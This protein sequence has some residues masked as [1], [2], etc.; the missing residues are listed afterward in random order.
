[1][2]GRYCGNDGEPRNL[3][4]S[5]N[6]VRVRFQSDDF[7]E[8]SGFKLRYWFLGNKSGNTSFFYLIIESLCPIVFYS[9]K[10]IR[11]NLSELL[12]TDT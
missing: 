2:L 11:Q 9:M 6:E 8:F 7:V 10:K 3:T 5:E 4:S 1:M 12:C